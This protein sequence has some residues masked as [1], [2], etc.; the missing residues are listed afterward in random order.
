VLI[1]ISNLLLFR[2]IR[3]LHWR[4]PVLLPIIRRIPKAPRH[5]S[6]KVQKY[7][8][9]QNHPGVTKVPKEQRVPKVQKSQMDPRVFSANPPKSQRIPPNPKPQRAQ[10]RLGVTKVL[11]HQRVRRVQ[12]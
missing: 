8:R 4:A 7:Q 3:H 1:N 11:N 9:V 6:L 5:Q 12:R 2:L 10:N